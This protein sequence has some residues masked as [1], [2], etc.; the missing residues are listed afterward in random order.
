MRKKL[1]VFGQPDIRKEDADEVLDSL[2]SLWIGTG[3]KVAQFEDK[4]K[5]YMGAPFAV[6]V[7]SCTAA[8]HLSLLAAGIKSGDEVITTPLTFAATANVILHVGAKPA[9]VDVDKHTAL[10]EPSLI[11]R[12][13]TSKTK[14][15]MPVHLCGRPCEMDEIMRIARKWKLVVIEDAAHAVEA[16]YKGKRIGTIGDFTCFS[17]YVNKNVTTCEGGM[18][19]TKR[20]DS[21][22]LIRTLAHHGLSLTAWE[23]MKGVSTYEVVEPGY[24]YNLTDINAALGLHQLDRIESSWKR[25]REIWGRYNDAFKK[26][27]CW[28]PPDVQDGCVHAYHL[29]TLFIDVERIGK[30]RDEVRKKLYELN[31]GTGIHYISLHLHPYYRDA[32]GYEPDDFP[33]ARWI[34]ERTLS[35]PPSPALTDEDVDDVI[36]A[37]KK[38]LKV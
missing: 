10:V 33:N 4:L 21:S 24:K 13:I 7:S 38:V 12:A 36:D 11:E 9:F 30:S 29:Y 8:L 25:R 15:I 2:K 27:A 17:F 37:V 19:T 3:P 26:F 18:V 16:I 31:I 34:S 22:E 28:T 32:F 20:Q 6:A 5:K 23:R 1:L 14:A 35:L